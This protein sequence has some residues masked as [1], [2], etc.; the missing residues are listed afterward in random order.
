MSSVTDAVQHYKRKLLRHMEDETASEVVLHC[1][2]KLDRALVTIEILQETGVGKVVNGLKKRSFEDAEVVPASKKLVLKW[3]DMVANEDEAVEAEQ[4]PPKLEKEKKVRTKKSKKSSSSKSHSPPRLSSFDKAMMMEDATTKKA[5][6]ATTLM[7]EPPQVPLD[8]NPNYKPDYKKSQNARSAADEAFNNGTIV[9]TPTAKK[10]RTDDEMLSEMMGKAKK[11]RSVVYSGTKR[12][13]FAKRV[14][15]LYELA[16]HV[17]QE[18]VDLIDE[19]GHA[20][21]NM[22]QPILERAKPE[23]LLHIENCNPRFMEDTGKL[24]E[25]ICHKHFPKESRVEFE[26]WR[27]MYERCTAERAAKLD[28]LAAKVSNSYKDLKNNQSQTRLAF[29]DVVAKPPRGVKR[30]QAKNGTGLA[31]GAPLEL[32]KQK[33]KRTAS[34]ASASTSRDKKPKV[35]PM[36]AKTLKL[37]R[38]LKAGFRR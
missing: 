5:K 11:T 14:P 4:Q 3:K 2:E 33:N 34:T 13:A 32:A 21:Y 15:S 37:A 22:M 38:G 8:L 12:S 17:L 36:M 29:V 18:N 28:K 26:S 6:K 24:W 9:T 10:K 35:A 19:V 23:T 16:V 7:A 27:E 20:D 30:A 31:V 25:R 1:L